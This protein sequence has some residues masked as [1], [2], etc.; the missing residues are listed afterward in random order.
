M[1]DFCCVILKIR[2]DEETKMFQE[3]QESLLKG[4]KAEV[5]ALV[6]KALASG[7]PAAKILNEGLI[8]GME[9][10]GELFKRN[11]VFIPRSSWLPGP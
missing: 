7:L 6:V 8:K 3:I 4:K 2:S 10:L 9:T 11:E 5:E 1:P